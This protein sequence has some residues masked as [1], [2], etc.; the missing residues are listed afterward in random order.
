MTRPT[1]LI[2]DEE[3]LIRWSLGERLRIEGFDVLEATRGSAV[4]R[5]GRGVDVVV[6][7][8]EMADRDGC[9][10]LRQ[11]KHANPL[12]PIILLTTCPTADEEDKATEMGVWA[13]ARKP[14]GL[15]GLIAIVKNAC[16]PLAAASSFAVH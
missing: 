10:V 16:R 13:V 8:C 5:L 6:L 11:L 15:D 4:E 2:A 1:V 14:F 12:V 9:N 7:G 3:S